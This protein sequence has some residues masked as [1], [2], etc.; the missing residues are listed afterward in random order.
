MVAQIP[1]PQRRLFE[2]EKYRESKFP[3]LELKH[4]LCVWLRVEQDMPA[5][6]IARAVGLH[7]VTVRV[8]QRD[9]IARGKDAF[10]SEKRGGRH[11]QL[12]TFEEEEGFLKGFLEAAGDASLLVV[13]EIKA[14]LEKK[15]GREVHKT[16]VYRILKRH[17]WRKLAPRPKHPKQDKEAVDA[18]KKRATW[19]R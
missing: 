3:V 8:I 17:G 15:L 10:I 12:M 18:F 5:T 4:F 19:K 14:A 13:S 11:R 2:L 16:T 9:F 1:I 6:E 7:E